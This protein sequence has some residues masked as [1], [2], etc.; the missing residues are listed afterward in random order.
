[1]YARYGKRLLDAVAAELGLILLLPIILGVSLFLLINPGRPLFYFQSRVG[2]GGKCFSIVKFRTMKDGCDDR[3]TITVL[4]DE[5]VTPAG[6]IFRSWKLDEIPQLWNVLKGEMSL[7]G[8]RP[9]VVDED[10][11]VAQLRA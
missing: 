7:V 4:G 3:L 9:L 8:P 10:A 11:H 6:R 5:R 2:R 1:M